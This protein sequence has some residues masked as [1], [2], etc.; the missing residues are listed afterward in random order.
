MWPAPEAREEASGAGGSI[1]GF[2]PSDGQQW[3]SSPEPAAAGA[4]IGRSYPLRFS[5]RPHE[6]VFRIVPVL[7]TPTSTTG[8]AE[9]IALRSARPCAVSVGDP[10]RAHRSHS[11]AKLAPCHDT[12]CDSQ[13][14]FD[15][16]RIMFGLFRRIRPSGPTFEHLLAD[17]AKLRDR[18]S[19]QLEGLSGIDRLTVLSTVHDLSRQMQQLYAVPLETLPFGTIHDVSFEQATMLVDEL[20]R[21][22]KDAEQHGNELAALAGAYCQS[23]ALVCVAGALALCREQKTAFI[24]LKHKFGQQ[25]SSLLDS[26]ENT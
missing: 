11:L 22:Y 3:P 23:M 10:G 14:S 21:F 13:A 15:V 1:D 2:K 25:T 16:G 17:A 8:I 4:P 18:V 9:Q 26:L 6:A 7:H 5:G 20:D 24:S 19:E 12:C